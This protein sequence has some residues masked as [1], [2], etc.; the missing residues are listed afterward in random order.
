[1]KKIINTK[2]APK[3]I[4]PY[5]QA[6]QHGNTLYISGQIA[7]DPKNNTIKMIRNSI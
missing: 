6:I 4:G 2:N 3:A 5:N 1:M 7:I